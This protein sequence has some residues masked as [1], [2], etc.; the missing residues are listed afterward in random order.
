MNVLITRVYNQLCKS[1]AL[2]E[3]GNIDSIE[4]ALHDLKF[5]SLNI[6]DISLR[7]APSVA[8]VPHTV[9][10]FLVKEL[11]FGRKRM[12]LERWDNLKSPLLTMIVGLARHH[13]G[14][15]LINGRK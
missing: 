13:F 1:W 12:S 4:K 8:H 9:L 7:V 3:L 5:K 11:F 15:Y 2:T 10:S 6:Q 14:Y